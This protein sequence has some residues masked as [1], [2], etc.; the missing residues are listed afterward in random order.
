MLIG[1]AQGRGEG[2]VDPSCAISSGIGGTSRGLDGNGSRLPAS[3]YS[4]GIGIGTRGP[5]RGPVQGIGLIAT[6]ADGRPVGQRI[7]KA[8]QLGRYDPEPG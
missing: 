8:L 5:G 4:G 6:S 1:I 3:D 7:G 2:V